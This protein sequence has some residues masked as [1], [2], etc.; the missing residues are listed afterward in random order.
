MRMQPVATGVQV[1][2]PSPW[3]QQSSRFTG[4][5]GLSCNLAPQVLHLLAK[6]NRQTSITV[7][8]YPRQLSLLDALEPAQRH[9]RANLH[10]LTS[11]LPSKVHSC[12][13]AVFE[14]CTGRQGLLALAPGLLWW[15]KSE[16][17]MTA[18]FMEFMLLAALLNR[19]APNILKSHGAYFVHCTKL[20]FTNSVPASA[21]DGI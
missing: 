18:A 9:A 12:V 6:T 20:H 7:C 10:Q 14:L 13:S 2:P 21:L 1:L 17:E 5:G 16:A 11:A 19:R 8:S 15:T 4:A 3:C